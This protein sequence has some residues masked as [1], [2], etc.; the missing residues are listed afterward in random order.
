MP[1]EEIISGIDI[2]SSKIR[3]LV[4]KST[5]GGSAGGGKSDEEEKPHIIGFGE[6]A[7]SGIRRGIVSD[8]EEAVSSISSALEQAERTSGVPVEHA[9]VNIEGSHITSQKS[10]G[11]IAVSRADNEITEDDIARVIDAAQAI[12]I[13]ANMEILHVIP[14]SF[15]VDSQAG[16]KDPIGMTGVRLEVEACIIQGATSFIK[17]L[18]KCLLR[19]GVDIDELVASPL[20]CASSILSKRQKELGVIL[21]DIGAGTSGLIV[22]EEGDLLHIAILPV[23]SSH[24]TNDL[25][26]GLRCSI[27]CAEKV[28]LEYGTAQPKEVEKREEVDLSKIDS[29]EEGVVA[30]KEIAEIIEAR[31]SEI[32]SLADKELKS[33]DRSAKLP[34][35]CVLVGGGAKLPGIIDLAKKELK[36]PV[37]IGFP[38]ELSTALDKMDDPSFACVLGLI[39]WG[40]ASGEK[41]RGFPSLGLGKVSSHIKKWFRYFLP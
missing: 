29:H 32:F 41:R 19:C 13:P 28:K 22:F 21:L 8:V 20:S 15:T 2:G 23:G 9:Y 24:I 10:K 39:M 4:A 3:C 31:L 36:L 34:A 6:V 26:I 40:T 30:R 33:I 7:S 37:Q 16:I 14:H 17:N 11:V 18:S 25:A 38:Q 27:D 1:R 35:G 12:S 5:H